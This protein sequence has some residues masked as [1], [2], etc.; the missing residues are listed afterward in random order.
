MEI[1]STWWCSIYFPNP[2]KKSYSCY[3]GIR[4]RLMKT[5][6]LYYFSKQVFCNHMRNITNNVIL[7]NKHSNLKV[8]PRNCQMENFPNHKNN[9]L[10]SSVSSFFF[11][12]IDLLDEFFF[13]HFRLFN[14]TLSN[15]PSTNI[16]V[17]NVHF[18]K[19]KV[20]KN[21]NETKNNNYCKM[22]TITRTM[23][24]EILDNKWSSR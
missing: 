13:K 4:I 14:K 5:Q 3:A 7:F 15:L 17:Q 11:I 12:Y 24:D 8:S 16:L 21:E 6:F 10:S 2:K 18:A 9:C 1:F 23:E 22:I 20:K 19:R